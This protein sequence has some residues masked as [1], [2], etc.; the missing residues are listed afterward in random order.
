M[1]KVFLF[2][3]L[4]LTSALYPSN[5]SEG[6]IIQQF[7]AIN[8][9]ELF[10]YVTNELQQLEAQWNQKNKEFLHQLA[11]PGSIQEEVAAEFEPQL[12]KIETQ[13]ETLEKILEQLEE[14][15]ELVEEAEE[16]AVETEELAQEESLT[17]TPAITIIE[18]VVTTS[19]D[20]ILTNTQT[21]VT[22]VEQ[23]TPITEP[24]I[25][26]VA[27]EEKPI[28]YLQRRDR[29]N[30]NGTNEPRKEDK[31]QHV[32]TLVGQQAASRLSR[33]DGENIPDRETTSKINAYDRRY[34]YQATLQKQR[35]EQEERERQL[36][37]KKRKK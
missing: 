10:G 26:K 21:P 23:I 1:K 31:P 30:A 17:T 36:A 29:G 37:E 8:Q 18:P 19:T 11:L 24:I 33:A 22:S 14:T 4:M 5:F 13:I 9:N 32:N 2:S 27:E 34:Q 3:A 12:E 7:K 25:E 28:V 6:E 16:I 35:E 20:S 15:E